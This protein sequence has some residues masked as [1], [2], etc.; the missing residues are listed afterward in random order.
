MPL[1]LQ[2]GMM[3]STSS[4][5]HP[6]PSEGVLGEFPDLVAE[7]ESLSITPQCYDDNEDKGKV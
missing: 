7:F 3:V 4:I 6:E 1:K 5:M 2:D